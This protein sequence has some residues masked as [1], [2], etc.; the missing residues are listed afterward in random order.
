PDLPDD[1]A[2]PEI[3]RLLDPVEIKTVSTATT[4]QRGGWA[5]GQVIPII[6]VLMTIT[7]AIYPAIDLTAGERERGTLETLMVTPVSPVQLITGKFLV[8]TTIGLLT[9]ALNVA[10]IGATMH[11]SGLTRAISSEMPVEFPL[12]VLPIIFVALIP[13]ACL[14]SAVLIAVCSFART[15]KEAQNYVMPV[16]IVAM[17]PAFAVTLPSVRL[18]GAMLVMPVGNM[19]LLTRELFQQT[20]TWSQIVVV[21]LST[22]LYAAA[23]VAVAARLF[24]QEAVLFAD[25]RSYKTMLN[26]RFFLPADRPPL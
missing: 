16:I 13:F 10:S 19:V 11:F 21:V 24:G 18:T 2:A 17:I 3:D 4:T 7:G 1:Q 8:V 6:L 20:H 14:F 9:A 15:F 22:G 12:S 5:L 25:S 23:A 26:R